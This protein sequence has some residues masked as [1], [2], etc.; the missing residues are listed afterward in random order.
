MTTMENGIL[1]PRVDYLC[2]VFVFHSY[3]FEATTAILVSLVAG[4]HAT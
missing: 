1:L 3:F 2:E 4:M